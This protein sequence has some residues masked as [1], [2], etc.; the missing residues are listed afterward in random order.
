MLYS[1]F[2]NMPSFILAGVLD[3]NQLPTLFPIF[4][5]RQNYIF[6]IENFNSFVFGT[7]ILKENQ[8]LNDMQPLGIWDLYLQAFY[9]L[10]RDTSS[11]SNQKAKFI[12]SVYE[13]FR[14]LSFLDLYADIDFCNHLLELVDKL[15]DEEVNKY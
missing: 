12:M 6:V 3:F 14:S 4:L 5:E 2:E 7:Y 10:K 13:L 1:L 15:N 8:K 9:S 11:D